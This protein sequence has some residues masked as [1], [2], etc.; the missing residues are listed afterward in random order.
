[1]TIGGEE[2]PD[3][4][5]ELTGD[6]EAARLLRANLTAIA[7]QHRGTAMGALVRDVL[8]GRRPVRDL[9]VD[10]EFMALTRAGVRQYQDHWDSLSDE[11]RRGLVLEA[12]A[13]LDEDA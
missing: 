3:P 10:G 2:R 7:E 5:T 8:A 11:E 12:E 13:L 6:P 4:F 1:M 9:E